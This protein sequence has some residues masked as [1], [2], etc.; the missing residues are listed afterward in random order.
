MKCPSCSRKL[1]TKHYDPEFEW[2]EC[3]GCEGA[4]TVDE[5]QGGTDESDEP[6]DTEG[7]GDRSR[8]KG[9]KAS[10]GR[11]KKRKDARGADKG[12]QAASG[13]PVAKGKK[14]RAE[15]EEDEQAVED[16]TAEIV[17]NTVK[18]ESRTK[19]RDEVET[20]AVVNIWGDEIQDV[21]HD[22]GSELDEVNAQD[23]ALIIWREIHHIQGVSARDQEVAH[24]LCKEHTE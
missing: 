24:A 19:H 7:E 12:V 6:E 5:I 4:F 17:Q 16:F 10:G 11:G 13:K 22:L 14:R 18:Q 2:Y 8:S 23:K 9:T 15:I 3:P 21:Y 1:T 20:L